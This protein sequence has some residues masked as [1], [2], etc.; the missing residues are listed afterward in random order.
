MS[1]AYIFSNGS[2]LKCEIL[3]RYLPDNPWI[4]CADGGG[5]YLDEL[6]LTPQVVIGD[7]D[8]ISA[9]VLEKFRRAGAEI[10]A[11]PKEKDYT[12]TQLAI[13]WAVEHGATEIT[14]CNGLGDRFD[15][16]LANVHLLVDLLSKGIKGQI[17][18]QN[19]R[20]FIVCGKM[21][22]QGEIGQEISFL[23]LTPQ[24]TG[25]TLHGFR[26]PLDEATLSLGNSI[27]VSNVFNQPLAHVKVREGL[28]LAVLI[29]DN[30]K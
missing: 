5:D 27:G 14:I 7:F 2:Y 8:S 22:L 13:N 21:E 10:V 30:S 12:D 23:P 15:H 4:I 26:Y 1:H 11:F 16:S 20:L 24:V 18:G 28:L 17:L 9:C 19:H 29:L 25:I 3:K 6:G